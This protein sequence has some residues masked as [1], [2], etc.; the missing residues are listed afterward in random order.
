MSIPTVSRLEPPSPHR[1]H[2]A[3]DALHNESEQAAAAAR[4]ASA[5]RETNP[6]Q[7]T[8]AATTSHGVHHTATNRKP[9][10]GQPSARHSTAR[11]C[12][13]KPCATS[14]AISARIFH[15][16]RMRR[17]IDILVAGG[18]L[19]AL[20][21]LL[22]VLIAAIRLTSRG[23]AIYRQQRVGFQG[24]VFTIFKLRSM[25]MDAER[26][27]GAVWSQPGDPRVT[28]L[29]RFLRWS[30][31]D[32]LPQL[33]NILRGDMALI[34]PRPERP[35]IVADLGERIPN[36]LDR[37]KVLPGV[38][39]LAQ[40]SLPPDSDLQSVRR[41]TALDR[42]YVE[43]VSATLDIHILFCTVMLLFG[44]QRKVDARTWQTFAT[45]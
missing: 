12:A 14:I 5:V 35:E 8:S 6:T 26:D 20:G 23:G 18:L 29:G 22:A 2:P 16:L 31:F 13:S 25:R 27:T 38:T 3:T 42:R 21:P 41:K 34:G 36:Y 32:E 15:Y 33:Y 45:A 7:S 17:A 24:R 19:V 39:G 30:H 40:V 1:P 28:L 4:R 9:H 37:L 10:G 44:L 43:T 11:V